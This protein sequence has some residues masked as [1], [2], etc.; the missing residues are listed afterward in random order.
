MQIFWYSAEMVKPN[1]IADGSQKKEWIAV[2]VFVHFCDFLF[3]ACHQSEI[4]L[5]TK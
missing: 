5:H 4:M 3:K 1:Y 2:N